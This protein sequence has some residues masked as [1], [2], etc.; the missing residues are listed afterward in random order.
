[1]EEAVPLLIL[2]FA[3]AAAVVAFVVLVTLFKIAIRLILLPLLLVKWLVGGVVLM[4]VGPI[5]ALVGIILAFAL[6]TVIVV[7]LL[8]FLAAAA[9]LYLLFRAAHPARRFA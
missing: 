5:L 4:I 2:A 1:V 9:V 6:G 3:G 7:P 8:P